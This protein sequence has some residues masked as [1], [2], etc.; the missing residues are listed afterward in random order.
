MVGVAEMDAKT[1]TVFNVIGG[2]AVEVGV[3]LAGF[4]LGKTVKDT[5]F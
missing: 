3:T 4:W 5:C 2:A 1:F